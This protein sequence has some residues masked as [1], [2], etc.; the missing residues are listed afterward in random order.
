MHLHT[1]L[2]AV[3]GTLLLLPF[4]LHGVLNYVQF[5]QGIFPGGEKLE[6]CNQFFNYKNK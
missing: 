3:L 6:L 4:P 5:Y 2:F 1:S